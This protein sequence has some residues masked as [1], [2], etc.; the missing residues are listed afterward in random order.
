MGRVSF[1]LSSAAYH[2]IAD[3]KVVLLSESREALEK[4]V[5]LGGAW[6]IVDVTEEAWQNIA[7]WFTWAA[8][9]EA[10]REKR[11]V[12]RLTIL[13][14]AIRGIADGWARSRDPSD[15]RAPKEGTLRQPSLAS[16]GGA[17]PDVPIELNEMTESVE[18]HKD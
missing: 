11:D 12:L 7:D 13:E 16:S 10:A 2:A 9:V 8:G 5:P 3:D 1:R 6:R 15:Q 18:L 17:I 4:A 14:G